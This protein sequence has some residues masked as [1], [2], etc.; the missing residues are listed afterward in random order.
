MALNIAAQYLAADQLG[1]LG[2]IAV[3]N[4]PESVLALARRMCEVIDESERA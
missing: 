2:F 1:R 3:M 4:S